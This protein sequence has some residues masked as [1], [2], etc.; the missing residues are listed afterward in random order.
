V[1]CAKAVVKHIKQS[2]WVFLLG[3]AMLWLLADPLVEMP[4]SFGSWRNALL[5]F[6]GV[7]AIG[8]M[9]LA[10]ILASRPVVLE[11]FLGGLD[12]MYRLHK[13]LGISA[14]VLALSHWLV[15]QVPG[16]LTDLGWMARPV[17]ERGPEPVAP[18]FKW[19]Q[20]QHGLAEGL[21]EWAFYAAVLLIGLALL[22]WFP[23]RLFF[24]THRLL[25]VAYLALVFHSVVLTKFSYWGQPL[26]P[27]MALLWLAGT[28]AALKILLGRVGLSRRAVG[29]IELISEHQ[30]VRVLELGVQIRSRWAGHQSGQFVFV[31]FDA[32]EGP[33]PFTISSAWTGDGHL[34]FL[35]KDLGD[36]TGS[37]P[38]KLKVGDPVT[39]EGPYGQFNFN[40]AGRRQI[41][42]GGGIGITPF[43]A[44]LQALKARS[45]TEAIDLFYATTSAYPLALDK[46]QALAREAEVNLHVLIEAQDGRLSAQRIFETVPDCLAGDLWFCG[47]AGFGQ[48]LRQDFIARGLAR[49]RFHEEL[50]DLR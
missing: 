38:G 47:P 23:Y 42:V 43:V 4:S 1:L 50:F 10:L 12:K 13:W 3:L 40:S 16:W 31:T 20:S 29:V 7:L 17:R 44:R 11:P 21:G 37:L 35:I 45:G 22:K 34:Q 15:K 39:L 6:S 9:S 18:I 36:Y 2:Y 48:A 19:L 46:L 5:N 24:K 30:P 32:R 26:G 41:W 33:H 8:V 25:A 28:V 27:V 49:A 14:L